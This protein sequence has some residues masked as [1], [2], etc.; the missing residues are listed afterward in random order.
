MTPYVYR[1]PN[2]NIEKL[3]RLENMTLT[4]DFHV[5]VLKNPLVDK[6]YIIIYNTF[7]YKNKNP[8]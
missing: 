8:I 5:S 1:A 2:E 6:R 3:H 4:T 7:C